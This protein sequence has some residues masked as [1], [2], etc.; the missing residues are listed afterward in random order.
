MAEI[1]LQIRQVQRGKCT[2]LEPSLHLDT[3]TETGVV[4]ISVSPPAPGCAAVTAQSLRVQL[5]LPPWVQHPARA[6]QRS[7]PPSHPSRARSQPWLQGK[8]PSAFGLP[9][10]GITEAGIKG[11]WIL[12][13]HLPLCHCLPCLQTALAPAACNSR[14]ASPSP[15]GSRQPHLPIAVIS[16]CRM[17]HLLAAF[18]CGNTSKHLRKHT[19]TVWHRKM[20]FRIETSFLTLGY[21]SPLVLENYLQCRKISIFLK[22][23]NFS[24]RN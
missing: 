17:P 6:E 19:E 12:S 10:T 15:W 1:M 24:M 2:G 21:L 5:S 23:P 14:N 22:A 3:W 13:P 4:P 18:N 20:L 16:F 8:A 7:E 9:G 11:N